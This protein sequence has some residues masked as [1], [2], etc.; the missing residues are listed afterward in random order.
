MHILIVL[1]NLSTVIMV[2]NTLD[3][4][5][6]IRP[7]CILLPQMS[8]YIKYFDGVGKNMSFK[9]EDDNVYLGYIEISNKIKRASNVRFHGQ[10][11]YDEKY[12]K[13]KLKTFNGVI[14]TV[15]SD[16]E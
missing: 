9:I 2:L 6:I 11:I 1:T 8:V 12:I 16:N 5:D 14:N 7:L 15:F 3:D 10:P 13:A 4:D